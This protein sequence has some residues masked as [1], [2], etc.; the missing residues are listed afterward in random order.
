[1]NTV[2]PTSSRG[3]LPGVSAA[4]WVRAALALVMLM[5]VSGEADAAAVDTAGGVFCNVFKNSGGLPFFVSAFAY[6]FGGS[7]FI[8]GVYDLIKR[9]SDPNVPLKN[10]LLG[11]SVGGAIIAMPHLVQ[12]LHHTI[13]S[14]VD[15]QYSTNF[16]CSPGAATT[17]GAAVPL[18]EMLA[19]FVNNIFQP[20]VALVSILAIIVGAFMIFYNMVKLS[21]L[22]SDGKAQTLTPIITALA[23]GAVLMALG[24][25]LNT[26]LNTLFGTDTITKYSSI[27]YA[28]GGS[29]DLT[30]F[31]R[32][33]TAVFAFL[34][35]IGLISFVRGFLILKNAVE[36]SGQ[37]T[38]GQAFTHIIGG[39]LLVNMPGF[40]HVIE[41]TTGVAI[42]AP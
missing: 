39:T 30:R 14:N 24:Q 15:T 34:Y 11:L 5:L 29:F 17:P 8:R 26:S 36:G 16:G 41:K 7:V 25:T 6:L 32:A 42:L 23:V 9:S 10:G 22:G 2:Q 1:M 33:M 20:L 21:K 19:N 31:N 37:Q 13:Y 38:K 18:D 28:P 12:W 3:F 35:V 4:E 40:I 27:A